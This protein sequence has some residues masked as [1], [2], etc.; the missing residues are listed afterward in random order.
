MEMEAVAIGLDAELDDVSSRDPAAFIL[1]V[2]IRVNERVQLRQLQPAYFLVLGRPW[3]DVS[4][5]E[6]STSLK[7]LSSFLKGVAWR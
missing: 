6:Y 4:T 5:R 2:V 7:A 1:E 3:L